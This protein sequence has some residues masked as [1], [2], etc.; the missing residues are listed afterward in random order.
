MKLKVSQLRQIIREEMQRCHESDTVEIMETTNAEFDSFRSSRRYVEDL[1]SIIDFDSFSGPG[2]VYDHFV[3]GEEDPAFILVL[4]D[5]T[6][7]DT[8]NEPW[9]TLEE[10]EEALYHDVLG[11]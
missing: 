8:V 10:A 5:G 3:E 4:D 6:F 2:Y 9:Q 11:Y 1:S 7:D